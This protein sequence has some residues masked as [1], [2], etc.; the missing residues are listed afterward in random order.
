MKRSTLRRYW[1]IPAAAVLLAGASGCGMLQRPEARITGASLRDVTATDATML[2]DVEVD[3]PYAVQLPLNDV[4]Y[5]LASAGQKFLTGRA[6]LDGAVP[7]GG[8]RTVGVPVRIRYVEL[9]DAV[10]DA[11]PGGTIPYDADLGLSVNVPA[12]GPLRLPAS[13]SGE[14][15]IPTAQGLLDRLRDLAR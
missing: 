10:K 3:N 11:R 6:E 8:S 13:R 7:A 9:I 12:L 2:F 4:D 5:S 14:L 1:L 15:R